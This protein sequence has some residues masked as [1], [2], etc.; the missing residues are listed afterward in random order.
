MKTAVEVFGEWARSGRDVRMQNGHER[1]VTNMMDFIVSQHPHPFR[2]IDAGC[3]NGWV[4]R[5]A[6]AL[7]HCTH[8]Q[9]VDGAED[10]IARA[11]EHDPQGSYTQAD[12]MEWV[13]EETVDVVHS[14]EVFYYFREPAKL[15]QHIVQ[16]WLKPGGRLITGLDHY[17]ENIPSLN[18]AEKT[19]IDFMTTLSE[20]T[21]LKA[22]ADAGLQ[23]VQ[24][25]RVD[26]K[27]EWAGTLVLTGTKP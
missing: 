18:W 16:H 9:G 24:S 26:A 11:K 7:E 21:W 5:R 12:L 3:G 1:S 14:M 6:S 13:P 27:D 4:V 20:A 25:W 22:F 15:I 10:M 2:F 17:Q 8:A 19:G 23:N